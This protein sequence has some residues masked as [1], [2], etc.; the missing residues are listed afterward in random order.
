MPA[1]FYFLYVL[2]LHVLIFMYLSILLFT[3]VIINYCP[4][5]MINSFVVSKHQQLIHQKQN[6]FLNFQHHTL[7]WIVCFQMIYMFHLWIHRSFI[8]V[9]LYIIFC[10]PTTFFDDNLNVFSNT[11]SLNCMT[12]FVS[13]LSFLRFPNCNGDENRTL[14]VRYRNSKANFNVIFSWSW[15]LWRRL[16]IEIPSLVKIRFY[17]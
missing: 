8:I 4:F 15:C 10:I 6:D 3:C 13:C 16:R 11:S 9:F 17:P 14:C 7:C 5:T 2:P 12:F 1:L